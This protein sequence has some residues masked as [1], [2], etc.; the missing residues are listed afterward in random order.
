MTHFGILHALSMLGNPIW[1]INC[2]WSLNIFPRT[3][4]LAVF[5]DLS[6][7]PHNLKNNC[8]L[9]G[10][11][12]VFW[13]EKICINI[14]SEEETLA[15]SGHLIIFQKEKKSRGRRKRR[16]RKVLTQLNLVKRFVSIE[17][18]RCGEH[19]D[20]L[21]LLG[22]QGHCYIQL[23]NKSIGKLCFTHQLS[24]K[25]KRISFDDFPDKNAHL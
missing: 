17:K 8:L 21:F 18:S 19:S 14:I 6:W 25:M 3:F 22:F 13:G 7:I 20:E 11:G 5:S 1:L 15:F 16:K 9:L 4:Q 2:A 10:W 12:C 24:G 23:R